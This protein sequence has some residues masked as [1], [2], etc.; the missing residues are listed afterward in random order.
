MTAGFIVNQPV[1]CFL[2]PVNVYRS[3]KTDDNFVFGSFDGHDVLLFN[4]SG[5]RYELF[6][7]TTIFAL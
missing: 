7:K 6:F 2:Q 3:R 5:Q 4:F 1:Y